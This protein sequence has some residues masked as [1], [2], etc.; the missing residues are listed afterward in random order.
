MSTVD[1]VDATPTSY[2]YYRHTVAVR[3]M[4]WINV[5]ALTILTASVLIG[6]NFSNWLVAPMVG[7]P[8]IAF[9]KRR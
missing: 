5:I 4:H 1:T 2:L 9:Q 3:I 8:L 6:L 7:R